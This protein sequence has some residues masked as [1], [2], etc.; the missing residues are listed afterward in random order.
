MDV[1][2]AISLIPDPAAEW[3]YR[4]AL[5][6]EAYDRGHAA[7]Y[8]EGYEQAAHDLE[9]NW[10]VLAQRIKRNAAAPTY[11]ELRKRRTA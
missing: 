8:H 3:R 4:R 5:C 9:R 6:H 11:A 2:D 10:Q 1:Q 7:G